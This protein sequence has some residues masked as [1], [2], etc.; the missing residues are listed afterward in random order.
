MHIQQALIQFIVHGMRH[1]DDF[2]CSFRDGR[3]DIQS[4]FRH[5]VLPSLMRKRRAVPK[6]SQPPR[7]A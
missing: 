5:L 4:L 1:G 6:L 2:R 3:Q 7:G